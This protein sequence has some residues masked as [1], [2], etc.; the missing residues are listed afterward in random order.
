MDKKKI[1]S[2][3]NFIEIIEQF[4]SKNL[5]GQIYYRGQHNGLKQ[6]WKLIPSFYRKKK[7]HERIPF[8][9][10]LNEELNSIYKF[11]EKNV[12]YFNNIDFDFECFKS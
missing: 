4:Q 3:S 12:D 7:T 10:D 11:V 5:L 6:N 1:T 8:Y 9:N 2:V